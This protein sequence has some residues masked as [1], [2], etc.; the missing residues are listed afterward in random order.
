[1]ATWKNVASLFDGCED[2]NVKEHQQR[3]REEEGA[4]IR[5]MMEKYKNDPE[6]E[7]RSEYSKYQEWK[8]KDDEINECFKFRK[9]GYKK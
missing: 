9:D 2:R 6:P 4:H 1:M 8:K 5:S 7:E 3:Q